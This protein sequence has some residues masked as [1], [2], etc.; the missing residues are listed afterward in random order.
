MPG[1]ARL[2]SL[3]SAFASGRTFSAAELAADFAVTA[4]TITMTD[5]L[6]TLAEVTGATLAADA[7]EDSIGFLPVLR[8]AAYDGP[9]HEAIVMHSDAGAFAIRQGNWKLLLAPGSG[10]A[11]EGQKGPT[12]GQPPVQLYDLASDPGETTNLATSQPGIVRRLT[13]ILEDYQKSG[14]SK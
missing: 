3:L 14:R 13:V 2:L 6:R 5:V 4:R 7:G 12:P 10:A 11:S 1:N 8:N 9:L